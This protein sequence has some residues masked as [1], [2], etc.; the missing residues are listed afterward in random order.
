MSASIVQKA[1]HDIG[2]YSCVAQKQPFL[3][4]IHKAGRLEF[5]R[6]HQKWRIEDWKKVI[7]TDES[8]F[9][10]GKSSC[11]LLMWQKSDERYRLDC[12]IP[13]F[14]TRRTSILIWG[15]FTATHKLSLIFMPPNRRT[16]V[17]YVEI[18]YDGC[19]VNF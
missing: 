9:E 6:K 1:L 15:G 11:Q 14:K 7:R 18:V 19:W 10:V 5:A 2:F 3:S 13:T 17:D 8:T 16:T 12:L 4:N